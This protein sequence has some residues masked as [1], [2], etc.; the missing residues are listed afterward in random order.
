MEHRGGGGVGGG[1]D[2]NAA[3]LRGDNAMRL[4]VKCGHDQ[5][6]RF[7]LAEKICTDEIKDGIVRKKKKKK[8]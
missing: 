1:V 5:V 8:T 3:D 4:A 7:L 6:V 2:V